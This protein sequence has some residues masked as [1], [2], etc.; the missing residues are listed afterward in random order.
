MK[1][2]RTAGAHAA[3]ARTDPVEAGR[4]VTETGVD[5]LAVAVGSS[6]AMTEQSALLD[7]QL[8]QRLAGAAHVPLVLHRASGV[9]DENVLS[10]SAAGIS[11]V[12]FGTRST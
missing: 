7:L 9:S 8:I 1:L 5:G 2:P 10:A 3:G 12:N 11:K 6:H 4:F